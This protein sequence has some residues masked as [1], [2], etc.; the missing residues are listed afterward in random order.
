MKRIVSMCSVLPMILI[1]LLSFASL[2]ASDDD[3]GDKN[4]L[5]IQRGKVDYSTHV[6]Q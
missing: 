1:A 5:L 4:Q 2:G 6:V 3:D